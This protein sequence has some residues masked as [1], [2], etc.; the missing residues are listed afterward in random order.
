MCKQ[1]NTVKNLNHIPTVLSSFFP[2]TPTNPRFQ[3][4]VL[5]FLERL[6]T[7]QTPA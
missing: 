6:I 7:V 1:G 4:E 2:A 5:G 3:E